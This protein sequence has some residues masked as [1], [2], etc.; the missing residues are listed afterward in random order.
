MLCGVTFFNV[1]F[2][3]ASAPKQPV[4]KRVEQGCPC[5]GCID[6]G[7]PGKQ[8]P[9]T[10]KEKFLADAFLRKWPKFCLQSDEKFP[11]IRIVLDYYWDD[12]EYEWIT[13]KS[14]TGFL[15]IPDQVWRDRRTI[16][17]M[18]MNRSDHVSGRI[19]E[20]KIFLPIGS[21]QFKRA[22]IKALAKFCITSQY[23]QQFAI[24]S[25]CG[26]SQVVAFHKQENG[27]LLIK[28]IYRLNGPERIP[29]YMHYNPDRCCVIL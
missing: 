27:E 15:S 20:S 19:Q 16:S 29:A 6:T 7:I 21:V 25:E 23:T 22:D 28:S 4:Y 18:Y 11:L 2:L 17:T 9:Y 13:L 14:I 12:Q 10:D 3:Q 26:L 8:H 1:G 24:Q 5:P